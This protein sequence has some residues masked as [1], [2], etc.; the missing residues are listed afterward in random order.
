M[1]N[2]KFTDWQDLALKKD[3]ESINKQLK[4]KP[5]MSV[6]I[7]VEIILGIITVGLSAIAIV[8]NKTSYNWLI[9]LMLATSVIAPLIVFASIRFSLY[10]KDKN[11][12]KE[13]KIDVKSYVDIFDNR[14]INFIMMASSL[15]DNLRYSSS[16]TPTEIKYFVLSETSYFINKCIDELYKM[17]SFIDLV[18]TNKQENKI[19]PNRLHMAIKLMIKLRNEVK[20]E[21][22]NIPTNEKDLV[23]ESYLDHSNSKSDQ[24]MNSFV[25]N[26]QKLLLSTHL[27][28]IE[29]N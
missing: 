12:I 4:Q 14:I 10:V 21:I 17:G 23:I 27:K 19:S 9:I 7:L 28:W 6:F 18:F 26:Y 22:H 1:R 25:T 8:S 15:M 2:V 5:V 29:W 20:M 13:N 11:R 24:K 3:I 16:S